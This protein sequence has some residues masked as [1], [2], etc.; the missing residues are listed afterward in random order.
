M[1]YLHRLF[2]DYTFL[3]AMSLYLYLLKGLYPFQVLSRIIFEAQTFHQ[4][5]LF[6]TLLLQEKYCHIHAPTQKDCYPIWN[7]S[8]GI[9]VLAQ[10]PYY[11]C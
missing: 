4:G 10:E 7:R 1:P 5:S 9:P 11:L 2:Q 8:A 6:L 3:Q